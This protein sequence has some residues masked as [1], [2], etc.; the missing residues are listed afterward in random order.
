MGLGHHFSVPAPGPSLGEKSGRLRRRGSR[1]AGPSTEL[2][3]SRSAKPTSRSCVSD[4][5]TAGVPASRRRRPWLVVLGFRLVAVLL[6]CLL[7]L[8]MLELALRLFGPFLPGN[9]DT[10][11]YVR[12]DPTLGHFH[13]PNFGGWHKAPHVTV[14]RD[15]T[16]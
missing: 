4:C 14:R 12:R 16:S 8:L 9:Y 11:P 3:M 13:L 2:P 7:P 10:G 5:S 6:G 1:S 15:S